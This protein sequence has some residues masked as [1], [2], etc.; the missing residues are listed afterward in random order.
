MLLDRLIWKYASSLSTKES[1]LLKDLERETHLKT[2]DPEM[3]SGQ[4]QGRILAFL[5][6]L[7]SPKYILEIGTFTGYATLCLAEGLQEGGKIYTIEKD[8][9]YL[10]IAKTFFA[11]SEYR[12]MIELIEGDALELFPTLDV[13]FDLIFIDAGKKEYLKYYEMLMD[14]LNP[15]S[16]I[17]ADNVLWKGRVLQEKKDERT[18]IIDD[19]N[20]RVNAD[21]RVENFILPIR[22][23]IHVITVK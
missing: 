22:D 13:D 8:P 15:G 4:M 20:R 3:I 5:S 17:L 7:K 12:G 1:S 10:H 19:F 6:K 23:G 11:K 14:A 9:E 21:D 2:R 18:Q 16:I